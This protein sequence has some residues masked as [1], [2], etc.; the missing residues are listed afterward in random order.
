MVT[1]ETGANKKITAREESLCKWDR[2]SANRRKKCDRNFLWPSE[3]VL[4]KEQTTLSISHPSNNL[5]YELFTQS[6]SFEV[7]L[8]N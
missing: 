4:S 3:T 6:A 1:P 7:L 2:S 5:E 8:S